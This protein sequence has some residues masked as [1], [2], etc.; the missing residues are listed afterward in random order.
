MLPFLWL[1]FLNQAFFYLHG[2]MNEGVDVPILNILNVI[3]CYIMFQLSFIKN[4]MEQK[5]DITFLKWIM[6]VEY[7]K[8]FILD[9]S[10]LLLQDFKKLWIKFYLWREYKCLW[11]EG[12]K[13]CSLLMF[14]LVVEQEVG[15]IIAISFGIS[16]S[17]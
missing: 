4:I 15:C 17:G 12:Y 1:S 11:N 2:L 10:W 5:R 9:K 16:K 14:L 13:I 6:H 8:C 7:F 3:N